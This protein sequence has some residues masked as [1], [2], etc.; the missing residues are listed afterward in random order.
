MTRTLTREASNQ[1]KVAVISVKGGSVSASDLFAVQGGLSTSQ[2]GVR[3]LVVGGT[4]MT[5]SAAP[6]QGV[7]SLAGGGGT[8]PVVKPQTRKRSTT[9]DTTFALTLDPMQ[10]TLPREITTPTA[11]RVLLHRDLDELDE[12]EGTQESKND[13]WVTGRALGTYICSLT[14]MLMYIV[15]VNDELE[16]VPFGE[17]EV[18]YA[19][20]HVVPEENEY[21][22]EEEEEKSSVSCDSESEE[23]IENLLLLDD[24]GCD[25]ED[26][27][28]NSLNHATFDGYNHIEHHE[29][30]AR[31]FSNGRGGGHASGNEVAVSPKLDRRGGGSEWVE[32]NIHREG[33][34]AIC[35]NG[36]C[37]NGQETPIEFE[38]STPS[39]GGLSCGSRHGQSHVE[40]TPCGATGNVQ[41]HIEPDRPGRS[42]PNIPS[43]L[44]VCL[45]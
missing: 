42:N 28:A 9:Q 43:S 38:L 25:K 3:N 41:S 36:F 45:D 11:V 13:Q 33:R 10:T 20:T 37:S 32:E 14:D 2:Q 31:H 12:G 4:R 29:E 18:L 35:S 15:D 22:S 6:R 26:F 27:M 34:E 1:S 23:E 44:Q 16:H 39:S 19:H 17:I 24:V 21:T 5:S 40:A 7:R 30:E 8:A